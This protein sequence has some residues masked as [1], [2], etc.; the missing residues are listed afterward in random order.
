MSEV[1]YQAVIART[2]PV[3]DPLKMSFESDRGRVERTVKRFGGE[4]LAD[5]PTNLD[6]MES[7]RAKTP[8]IR[9]DADKNLIIT[10]RFPSQDEVRR[11][12][13]YIDSHY[14]YEIRG[15]TTKRLCRAPVEE[16]AADE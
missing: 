2:R 8:N 7:F 3:E 12:E 5:K 6:T 1:E 10:A 13:N 14:P 11:F 16:L 15:S 9:D 4:V